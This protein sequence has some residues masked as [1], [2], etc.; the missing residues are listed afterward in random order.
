MS[1]QIDQLVTCPVCGHSQMRRLAISVNAG[2]SPHFREELFQQKLH[3]FLCSNCGKNFCV[4]IEMNW[5]DF[6]RLQWIRVFPLI[7]RHRWH[8]LIYQSTDTYQRYLAD[9]SAPAIA[10]ELGKGMCVR[11][12][13]GL[14]ALREKLIAWDHHLDDKVL[15][16]CQWIIFT[17]HS[18]QENLAM[19]RLMNCHNNTLYF[20]S[21]DG[22]W[23]WEKPLDFYV[24][25]E[26]ALQG[27]HQYDDLLSGPWVDPMRL[28]YQP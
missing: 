12:V 20:V 13:F 6:E 21:E 24:N 23:R 16:V 9:D 25:T 14:G 2:R 4:D 3:S 27:S 18:Q 1:T 10:R 19:P 7:E 8:E 28:F 22:Q 11:S 26:K 17:E 5:I 15:S